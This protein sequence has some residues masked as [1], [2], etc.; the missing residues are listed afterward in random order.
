MRKGKAGNRKDKN[1]SIFRVRLEAEGAVQ[2][3]NAANKREDS[4]NRSS[5]ANGGVKEESGN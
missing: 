4:L 1:L 2:Q 5:K 3:A